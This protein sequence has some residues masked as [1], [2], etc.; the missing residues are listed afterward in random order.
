M[1]S[2]LK[3]K[4][5]FRFQHPVF[6]NIMNRAT[7]NC[8]R[9]VHFDTDS[10]GSVM[11]QVDKVLEI[12]KKSLLELLETTEKY[13][14][15]LELVREANLTDL[16]TEAENQT[17]EY[18]LL[19]PSNEVFAEQEEWYQ[20]LL[21]NKVLLEQTIKSHILP[22]VLCCT[23][24]VPSEWPFIRTI[25]TISQKSLRIDRNRRPMIG[26]AGITKC[27][28]VATNG[29]VHEINDVIVIKESPRNPLFF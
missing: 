17:Q 18:T 26:N 3:L 13:S 20:Q 2:I 9:L 16:F 14:K 11:H 22:D 4:P 5:F 29:V 19:V 27:D 28:V 21:E 1:I 15:F 6:S 7:V 8:A 12:P 23:G 25:Q 24:F 10:C